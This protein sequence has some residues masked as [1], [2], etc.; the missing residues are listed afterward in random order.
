VTLP[1]LGEVDT[2]AFSLPVFTLV[3]A[4]LDSFNPCAFFVL[5][6]LLSLLIHVHSRA[7]MLLVGGTFVFFSG[8]LYFLFMSAWLN[9]FV[10][11]GNRAAI[12]IVAALVALV[13][14]ALNVKDFFFFEQGVSLVIPERAKPR[15]FDRMRGIVQA[16]SLPAMLAGTVALA[17]AANTYEL[18]CTAGF[19]MVYT[20][21]LTLHGLR[22]AH[23]YLYLAFY[24]VIYVVPLC[25]VVLFFVATLGS[26]K[27]TEWQGRVLKLLSGCMM[28]GLGAVLLV[29][30]SLLSS[31]VV[32][33]S[34][35]LGSLAAA[36]MLAFAV[37][38][39]EKRVQG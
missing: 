29:K 13:V 33:V 26:H 10:L 6:F 32:S 24:N 8:L 15:L 30:P 19:P 35:L 9:L 36:F 22:P 16:G 37:R 28:G 31:V 39:W 1:L 7:R 23:Y 4:G 27:L 11:A 34:L 20:R 21:A 14:A 2:T 5:F 17:V 3:L 38:S 18:L 12:N 25:G